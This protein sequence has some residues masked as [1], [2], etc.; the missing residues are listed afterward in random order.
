LNRFLYILR[1]GFVSNVTVFR[2]DASQELGVVRSSIK[3]EGRRIVAGRIKGK[4]LSVG[5]YHTYPA[6]FNGNLLFATFE[7]E[8]DVLRG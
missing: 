5:G 4:A 2:Q 7:N 6:G 3:F 1:R 8:I